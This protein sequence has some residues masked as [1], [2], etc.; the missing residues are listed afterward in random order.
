MNGK[1]RVLTF[2]PSAKMG[3][4]FKVHCRLLEAALHEGWEVHY[5]STQEFPLPDSG[6]VHFH[7]VKWPFGDGILFYV[8]FRC[9]LA[10]KVL[11]L[12]LGGRFDLIVSSCETLSAVSS[13]GK[14]L[15][16]VPLFTLVQGYLPVFERSKGFSPVVKWI[17][18]VLGTIGLYFSDTVCCVSHDLA[19][20]IRSHYVTRSNI[21]VIH[22]YIDMGHYS[23]V[24][25][26]EFRSELGLDDDTYLIGYL[27]RLVPLKNVE[28]L[29]ESFDCMEYKDARLTIVGD[30]PEKTKLVEIAKRKN[31]FERT[32]FVS[33]R[34]DVPDIMRSL[35]LLVLPS[36]HEACPLVLLEALGSGTVCLGSRRGGIPEILKYDEL[37]FNLD[38]PQ[39]LG[40]NIDRLASDSGYRSQVKKL[41]GKR[42]K[43]M[44]VDWEP[45]MMKALRRCARRPLQL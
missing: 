13:V 43:A 32:H 14:T 20:R 10:L 28:F 4:A 26:T 11:Y 6:R 35:D 15:A 40:E 45:L 25:S 5:I 23:V 24:G 38:N 18:R 21:E 27:G 9:I 33:Y 2:Y 41:S 39:K 16:G 42:R 8:Y 29:L 37:L 7:P 34:D 19:E 3:G 17:C 12:V 22:N 30:G 36:F 31:I 1:R 44:R